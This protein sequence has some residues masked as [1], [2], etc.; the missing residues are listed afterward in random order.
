MNKV[1][2]II[3]NRNLPEPTEALVEHIRHYDGDNTD[4][5]VVEAGSDEENL[6]KYCT[7]HAAWDD[8]KKHGLRYARG[9]NYGLAQL[10]KEGIFSQYSAFFL[11]TNDTEFENRQ[12]IRP[13]MN[14]LEEHRRVGI[15]SPCSPRWGERFLL[16]R[17]PTKY[18]WF[19]HNNAL[20]LR[21][22]FVED[23]CNHEEPDYMHFLFDGKNFRGYCNETELIAKAY[24][25]DWAAAITNE[26]H[27]SE[28]ES[29][30]LN[31]AD[32][33]KTESYDEN[34][35]LYIEEGKQWMKAKYGFKSHWYM[36]QYAKLFY[37]DFFKL[38]PEYHRFQL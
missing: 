13:L 28:N 4:V 10:W 36:Q 7:W 27:V 6:S 5:F 32:I 24:V 34:L 21:R 2:T 9:M 14:I 8:A 26:V 31:K 30:L 23:I 3:L 20:M 38:R 18:F 16:N 29:H 25:N 37:D 35:K 1:A 11:L 12:T 17:E 19:I 15:L 22:E 33:I